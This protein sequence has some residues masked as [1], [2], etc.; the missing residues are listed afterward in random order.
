MLSRYVQTACL[1]NLKAISVFVAVQLPFAN[2]QWDDVTYLKRIFGAFLIV[3]HNNTGNHWN[4]EIKL[5]KI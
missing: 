4:P 1:Q 2:W 5:E 3:V